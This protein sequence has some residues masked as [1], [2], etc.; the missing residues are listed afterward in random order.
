MIEIE[1]EDRLRRKRPERQLYVPPHQ[2]K[3]S[4]KG[5]NDTRN[6]SKHK[7]GSTSKKEK[8]TDILINSNKTENNSETKENTKC[9]ESTG[10]LQANSSTLE[11]LLCHYLIQL[12]WKC[13]ISGTFLN[14]KTNYEFKHHYKEEIEN[15]LLQIPLIFFYSY[16][17][18][19][20]KFD[21]YNKYF[22]INTFPYY[23]IKKDFQNP[24]Y[25]QSFEKI[26]LI[27]ND[28]HHSY[29]DIL[30]QFN[31]FCD[32]DIFKIENNLFIDNSYKYFPC[33]HIVLDCIQFE[34]QNNS[35]FDTF[36]N[37]LDT[38]LSKIKLSNKDDA[39]ASD[40]TPINNVAA[41]NTI[42]NSDAN[43]N[44]TLAAEKPLRKK[45]TPKKSDH[46]EELEIMRKTKEH[47]NRKT[48]PIMKYVGE[49][50][51]TLN[52]EDDRI[53]SW[54]DLFDDEGEVKEELLGVEKLN[55]ST[56]HHYQNDDNNEQ[57]SEGIKHI[58]ELEHLVELYDF[59]SSF[60]TQDLIQAFSNINCEAMYVKWVDDTHAI[61]VLG[62]LSQAMKAVNMKNPLIKARPMATASKTT[63]AV[64]NKNDLKP[65]MKRPPTNLQAARRF[66][67]A[68]LG[69][70][71]GVSKE[72]MAKERED[73]KAA[74]ELK[75]MLRKNEQDAWEGKLQSSLQ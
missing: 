37:I 27:I 55:K 31:I 35:I 39:S 25:N 4:L 68:A 21:N 3:S 17:L 60:K 74:R 65:A 75:K 30:Q 48:R 38:S 59:P 36:D 41:F 11:F 8:M 51:D 19:G 15:F 64:A 34:K 73:L 66:I 67:T 42:N 69:T 1:S 28:F 10:P 72:R 53:K 43:H 23:S 18:C 70:K 56:K 9:K 14:Y 2:R 47:I 40:T 58:E 20:D 63:L 6:R 33:L 44:T 7:N 52:I 71:I 12:R 62:T 22:C 54:E 57:T 26:P 50:N 46:E 13:S 16:S 5:T 49:S 24:H 45:I 29:S 32:Y 61:L